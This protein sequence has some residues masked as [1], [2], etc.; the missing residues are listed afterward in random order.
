MRIFDISRIPQFW[1]FYRYEMNIT[2]FEEFQKYLFVG[3]TQGF[4]AAKKTG[5][6]AV[7]PPMSSII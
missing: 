3:Y 4:K 7:K 2:A 6:I 1:Q 5:L